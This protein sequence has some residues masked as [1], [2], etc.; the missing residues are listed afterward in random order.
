MNNAFYSL[1]SPTNCKLHRMHAQ[2]YSYFEDYKPNIEKAIR[3]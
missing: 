2:K 3:M 1:N